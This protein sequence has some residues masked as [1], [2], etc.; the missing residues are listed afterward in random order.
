M[1]VQI[2]EIQ[3]PDEAER[4]IEL[5]VDHIGSVILSQENWRQPHLKETLKVSEG[6]GAKNSL[7]PLFE[8][9]DLLSRVLD[10]YR[11]HLFHF[12]ES[13]T[14]E[15]GE[16][17]NL[18]ELVRLQWMIK[19]RFPQLGMI[20]T[21]PIPVN[22][23]S[24]PFPALEMAKELEPVSDFFLTDTWL[25]K[26]PVKGFIGITGRICD[27]TMAKALVQ[28]SK[29]PVILAGGLSPGNAYDALMKTGP[30]GADSCTRTNEVD[31]KGEPIRFR[32]DFGK[33]KHFVEAVRRAEKDLRE[34]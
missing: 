7:I 22:S 14:D 11:P 3:R 17:R 6:T 34:I 10:Y 27:W 5:G 2:Y 19:E 12:C 23:V 30:A 8:D 21:I 32:K 20:R 4:C 31:K 1:I 28:Q 9:F 13:L 16:K 18:E 26:E 15:Y 24:S 29:I 33:V 25:G